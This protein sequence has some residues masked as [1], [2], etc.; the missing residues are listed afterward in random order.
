M[1]IF[2][3]SCGAPTEIERIDLSDAQLYDKI[4][5]KEY[6][7]SIS[8]EQANVLRN[9]YHFSKIRNDYH[10][11]KKRYMNRYIDFALLRHYYEDNKQYLLT[12]QIPKELSLELFRI[13][14]KK[15]FSHKKNNILEDMYENNFNSKELTDDMI[16]S[17]EKIYVPDFNFK[18][19]SSIRLIGNMIILSLKK[20]VKSAIVVGILAAVVYLAMSN[21]VPTM[22]LA[23]RLRNHPLLIP[24]L[25][26]VSLFFG[27]IGGI[28]N[29]KHF[30]LRDAINSCTEFKKHIKLTA[31]KQYKKIQYRIKKGEN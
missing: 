7:A 31:N 18:K 29:S 23:Y 27:F 4:V 15:T 12:K 14:D 30:P 26:A 9:A 2:C 19:L 5:N 10:G 28:R 22:I 13:W 11:M 25:A 3:D 21:Y 24:A 16:N 20:T 6:D 8:K 1:S 17:V